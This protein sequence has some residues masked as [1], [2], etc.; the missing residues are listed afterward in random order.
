MVI[1]I[2]W[3]NDLMRAMEISGAWGLENIQPVTRPEPEAGP[4]E[5]VIGI[6]AISI[7]PRDRVVA[8]GGYGRHATLPLVPLC[9][10]AGA[11]V[12]IGP[13]VS[14]LIEGELVCPI[15]SRTWLHGQISRDSYPGAHGM[16]LDGTAQELF[17]IPAEAV[18]RAPKHLTAP[19]RRRCPAPPSPRE[20]LSS[21]RVRSVPITA[22]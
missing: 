2:N 15:Y 11:I 17:V 13:G 6:K 22:F 21:N 10:G 5:I 8:M 7:N 4:G 20:M 1:T 16:A 14:N 9:D 19:E 12:D 18:V 3:G